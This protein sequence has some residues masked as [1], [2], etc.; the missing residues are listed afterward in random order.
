M[1]FDNYFLNDKSRIYQIPIFIGFFAH[2]SD[3]VIYMFSLSYVWAT[4]DVLRFW[5]LCQVPHI[6]RGEES[7]P[8]TIK[9]H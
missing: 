5:S 9:N 7:A 4:F 8:K 3:L 1:I 6:S 2:R